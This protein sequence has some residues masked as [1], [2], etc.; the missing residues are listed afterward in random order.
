MSDIQVIKTTLTD[1]AHINHKIRSSIAELSW[2]RRA[3]KRNYKVEHRKPQGQKTTVCIRPAKYHNWFSP[4]VWSQIEIA[5]RQAGWKMGA[6]DIVN[7]A[8]RIDPVVFKGLSC[9]TVKSWIDHSGDK[10]RWT[11]AVLQ[12]IDRGNVLPAPGMRLACTPRRP[13]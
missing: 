8:K 9:T 12:K 10:P 2:P 6:S 1:H 3:I 4:F 5:V 11:N 7:T 13:G